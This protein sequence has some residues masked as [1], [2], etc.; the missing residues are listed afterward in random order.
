MG[1]IKGYYY[2]D[3][4]TNEYRDYEIEEFM[5]RMMKIP[6]EDIIFEDP[7]PKEQEYRSWVDFKKSLTYYDRSLNEEYK[8]LFHAGFKNLI[9]YFTGVISES[10]LAFYSLSNIKADL[11]LQ[12]LIV[13]VTIAKQKRIRI[14][15]LQDDLTFDF[16]YSADEESR[17]TTENYM[18]IIGLITTNQK[19]I[20]RRI[21]RTEMDTKKGQIYPPAYIKNFYDKMKAS[22]KVTVSGIMAKL[23]EVGVKVDRKTVSKYVKQYEEEDRKK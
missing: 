3:T 18:K 4:E 2:N 10:T 19:S 20:S 23:E 7:L 14:M 15:F 5:F 21:S 11:G 12:F 9:R 17:K 13:L 16:R 22:G 8:L 1:E 6:E